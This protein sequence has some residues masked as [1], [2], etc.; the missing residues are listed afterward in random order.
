MLHAV[1][2][3]V[4]LRHFTEK[5]TENYRKVILK[6]KSTLILYLLFC[7]VS[8][9]PKLCSNLDSHQMAAIYIKY[10]WRLKTLTKVFTFLFTPLPPGAD[11]N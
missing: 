4:K 2:K 9:Y 10:S 6:L 8:F 5:F 11:I 7:F 3:L 1:I